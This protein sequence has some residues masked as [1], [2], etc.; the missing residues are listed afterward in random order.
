V[1]GWLGQAEEDSGGR[2][3][4]TRGCTG[5]V[6]TDRRGPANETRTAEEM[7]NGKAGSQKPILR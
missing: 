5:L 4:S 3:N 6:N 1:A 7:A 2:R